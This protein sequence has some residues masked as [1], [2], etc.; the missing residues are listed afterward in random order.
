MYKV[1]I[2]EDNEVVCL[3]DDEVYLDEGVTTYPISAEDFNLIW[4]SGFNTDWVYKEGV[5]TYMPKEKEVF[6]IAQ[7]LPLEIL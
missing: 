6:K 1:S 5:V 3:Y 2:N 4:K 7:K